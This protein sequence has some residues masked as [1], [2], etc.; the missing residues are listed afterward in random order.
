MRYG[1]LFQYVRRSDGRRVAYQV[2][3]AGDL[4][5]VFLLGWPTHLGLMWENPSFAGFLR[6]LSSF[7]RLILFDR[8]GGGLSDR[9]GGGGLFE[10]EMDDARAVLAAVG[11]ER[12]ALFGCHSGGRLALLMAATYPDQVSAVVTFGSH[13]ATLRDDDYPWGSTVEEHEGLLTMIRDG[14]TFEVDMLLGMVGPSE[15]AD[16]SVRHWFRMFALSGATLAE[17][18]EEIRSLG[19]VDI[20]GLLGSVQAPVLVLH[21]GG[22]RAADVNASRYMAERIPGARFVELPGEDHFPFF[23]DQDRV[24]AETQEFLTGATPVVEPDRV[25]ATVLFSD[26]VD[27]TRLAAELGDR[28]WHRVLVDHQQAVRRQLDRFRGHEIKT[29]GDGFL[30]TFDGPARAIRAA[31]ALRAGLRELDL[32]VRVGLHTGECELLDKDIGGIAVHIAARV[33]G[34]A[35]AGE[36]LCSRTVKDL[37]AGSGFSFADRGSHSLKGIPDDWQLYAVELAEG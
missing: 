31:D 25:L 36:I 27:S 2:V 8:V 21:R 18:Y 17:Q 32:E 9:G 16:P 29:I 3:G 20:R 33:L 34:R 11:S 19:P 1:P 37:A 13:P 15:V 12:A 22:D 6:K 35:E 23:G 4:D 14:E 24:I 26:I 28:R 5:L 30:A 10:D 7:S